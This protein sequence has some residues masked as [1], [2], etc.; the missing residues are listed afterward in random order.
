[1]EEIPELI[2]AEELL[3]QVFYIALRDRRV[4][5]DLDLV[6][7]C[8]YVDLADL[9]VVELS[10]YFDLGHEERDQVFHVEHIILDGGVT[11]HFKCLLHLSL[12]NSLAALR[13]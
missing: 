10:L 9:Q 2:L 7:L 5:L 6:A 8:P 12:G 13:G 4:T 3:R 11:V 1:M